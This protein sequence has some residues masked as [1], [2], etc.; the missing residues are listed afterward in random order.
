[1]IYNLLPTYTFI[2][3]VQFRYLRVVVD[4]IP[5][6]FNVMIFDFRALYFARFQIHFHVVPTSIFSVIFECLFATIN[7]V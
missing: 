2:I 4:C 6:T 5:I 7:P 1:M 3:C